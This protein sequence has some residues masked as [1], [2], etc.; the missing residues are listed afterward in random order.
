MKYLILLL[1][2]STNVMSQ[3]V[4]TENSLPIPIKVNKKEIMINFEGMVKINGVDLESNAKISEFLKVTIIENNVIIRA[5]DKF[6]K[7][8]VRVDRIDTGKIYLLDLIYSDY[9]ENIEIKDQGS[10][11]KV[12]ESSNV[13]IENYGNS[14]YGLGGNQC[15][16]VGCLK[17][18]RAKLVRYGYQKYYAPKR[19]VKKPNDVF[20]ST[21]KVTIELAKDLETKTIETLIYKRY[22]L[23]VVEVKNKLSHPIKIDPR[24]I[25][26]DEFIMLSVYS[27]S[28]NARSNAGDSTLMFIVKE[29]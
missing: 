9:S 26:H 1:L 18:E 27:W 10:N 24:Y 23:I 8:R 12:A 21:E 17:D 22:K 11:V 5:I 28:L 4:I 29:I 2:F 19:L 3:K 13:A 25:Y 15:S 14:G 7:L 20:S 6:K 16:N